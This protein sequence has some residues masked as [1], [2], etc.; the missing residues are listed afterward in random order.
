VQDL[1]YGPD[2]LPVALRRW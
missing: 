2:S 1:L